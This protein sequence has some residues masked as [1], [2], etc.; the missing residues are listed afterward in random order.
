M[1]TI[2]HRRVR[3]AQCY[4]GDQPKIEEK[5][6]ENCACTRSDFEW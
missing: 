1:Q 4:I 3:D 5:V 6:V 2:Y